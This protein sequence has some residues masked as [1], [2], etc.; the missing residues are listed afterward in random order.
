[1]R[2]AGI[3]SFKIGGLKVLNYGMLF[4]SLITIFTPLVCGMGLNFLLL[5]RVALGLTEGVTFPAVF[6]IFS[7]WI[8]NQEERSS[9]MAFVSTGPTVGT[10]VALILTPVISLNYGWRAGFWIFGMVGIFL[11]SF[12]KM[13]KMKSRPEEDTLLTEEERKE[14][15]NTETYLPTNNVE[16]GS[17]QNPKASVEDNSLSDIK[18]E[19]VTTL[20]KSYLRESSV[21]IVIFTHSCSSFSW[22]TMVTWLV[23]TLPFL[24]LFFNSCFF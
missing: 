22:V 20:L 16:K 1:M 12:S 6:D 13:K 3:L 24:P 21:W 7:H 15:Q 11:V 18:L 17:L 2:K 14:F 10:I 23:C 5:S 9:S 4:W 8:V 19:T